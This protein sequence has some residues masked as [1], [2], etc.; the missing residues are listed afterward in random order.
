MPSANIG[1]PFNA[2][3][4]IKEHIKDSTLRAYH[5]GFDQNKFRLKPLAELISEVIPEFAFGYH[6]SKNFQVTELR[7][8]LCEAANMIYDT[9][10]YQNRGEF[11][12]LILHL[13]LR[14]YCGS[15]P[16]L[17]KIYFK[18]SANVAVHGFDGVHVVINGTSKKL[19][20]GES[21]I[22]KVGSQG[23]K[24]LASDLK[25]HIKE[26]YLRR[27]FSIIY[28]KIPDPFPERE[29]W[30]ELMH[31]HQTLDNIMDGITLPMVCTY[32]SGIFQ[33]HKS[34]SE[35]YFDDFKAECIALKEEFE[36]QK[37]TIGTN[38]DVILMLLPINDKDELASELN[39]R[40]S[41]MRSI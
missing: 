12:E 8:R 23:V 18:D 9:D 14:S 10:K 27:E 13:L 35:K 26:D 37:G 20:L 3:L 17:S 25:K 29:F 22:Y 7:S 36:K 11:G 4:V 21:K 40:L 38:I 30:L 33:K 2:H 1:L 24:S 5:V 41:H 16:L 15:I 6:A 32:S 39:K 31:R 28:K 34:N 19:W